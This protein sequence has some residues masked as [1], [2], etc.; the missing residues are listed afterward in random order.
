MSDKESIIIAAECDLDIS[1]LT[2]AFDG[3]DQATYATTVKSDVLVVTSLATGDQRVEAAFGKDGAGRQFVGNL[4]QAQGILV[5]VVAALGLGS[6]TVVGA[7]LVALAWFF[8]GSLLFKWGSIAA[9]KQKAVEE[10]RKTTSAIKKAR[11]KARFEKL[12]KAEKTI[13]ELKRRKAF[14]NPKVRAALAKKDPK[15]VRALEAVVQRG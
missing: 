11:L 10:A 4:V 15:T 2:D 9:E 1:L 6:L 7:G 14:Q 3:Y 13:A 5:I 8:A 12:S